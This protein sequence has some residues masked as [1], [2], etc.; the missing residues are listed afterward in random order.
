[1]LLF[2]NWVLAIFVNFTNLADLVN[3]VTLDMFYYLKNKKVFH[4]N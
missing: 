4:R 2:A 1:M 3:L